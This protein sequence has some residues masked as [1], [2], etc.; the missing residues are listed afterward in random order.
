MRRS[1]S[2]LPLALSLPACATLMTP[3]AIDV[4]IDSRPPGAEV[5]Y[6]GRLIGR[7]PCVVPVRRGEHTVELLLDGYHRQRV[8]VGEE[9]NP[10][11]AGNVATLGL[12][13]VVDVVLG[14]DKRP[15][16]EP[17]LVWLHPSN[18]PYATWVRLRELPLVEDS[19]S[20]GLSPG[21]PLALSSDGDFGA[22]LF[23]IIM[24]AFGGRGSGHCDPHGGRGAR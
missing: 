12:G 21:R 24:W 15:C 2:A 19:P 9:V 6:E 14:M 5:I 11:V 1:L 20:N 13:V 23:A 4:P 16:T 3:G 8:D 18:G 17:A 10:W 7:T 22:L